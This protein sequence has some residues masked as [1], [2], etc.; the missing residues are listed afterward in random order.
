MEW[1]FDGLDRITS[2]VATNGMDGTTSTFGYIYDQPGQIGRLSRV[3]EMESGRT[4]AFTYDAVGRTRFETTTE[5]GLAVTYQTEY[6]YDADGDLDVVVYP[7]GLTVK[8]VRDAA[9]KQVTEVRNVA[10]GLKYAA[11]VSHWPQGPVSGLTFG[12]GTTLT[13][14]LNLRYEPTSIT[15]GPVSLVY[16]MTPGGDVQAIQTG[17][18][19]TTYAH[20]FLDRLVSVQPGFG[21]GYVALSYTYAGD[22]VKEAW[23]A[24]GTPVRK[25]AYGYDDRTNLS[26]VSTYDAAGT[27]VTGTTCLVHDGANR[28]VA[29][30]PA[31]AVSQ[32]DGTA[33]RSEGDIATVQ[34]RF[35]YDARN[36]RVGRWDASTGAWKVHAF[37]GDG[38]PLA[39]LGWSGTA[40]VA[41]REYVWLDGR[42]LAQLDAG[43]PSY[44]HLDQIGLPR[45]MTGPAGQL[46]WAAEAR[47]YGD[48]AETLTTVVTNLRLPG[49]YDERLLGGIGVQGPFYNW[50]RWYLPSA[51]RY[52]ELDPIAASGGFNGP[53][54]PEWFGY[55]S[56]RPVSLQDADGRY[57]VYGH[58]CGPD[59][60]GGTVG[61]YTPGGEGSYAPPFD[62]LDDACRFHDICYWSCRTIYPCSPQARSQCFR[63]CDRDLTAAAFQFGGFFGNLVG[64]AIDRPGERDPGPND[65]KCDPCH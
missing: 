23:T 51:G 61:Q 57:P 3:T 25:Y 42:P 12:N 19:T 2:V 15:S 45:A 21:N 18:T 50:N 46:V 13:Q 36:R 14:A 26:A 65:V 58:Y 48:V 29:V 52:L 28:L 6:R 16:T 30:G 8:Y 54:G 64:Y 41:Q 49:Q 27:T 40:W 11:G 5:A 60:T 7:T 63:Q 31:K 22:R 38:S 33:C 44:L 17:S 24:A 53:W 47:P 9:T 10:S 34:V 20:D 1:T 32:P 39:E 62:A 59:W 43:T 4:T 55:A 35:R 37:Q 56:G